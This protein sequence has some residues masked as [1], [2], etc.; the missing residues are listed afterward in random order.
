MASWSPAESLSGIDRVRTGH[1]CGV[2]VEITVIDSLLR[3]LCPAHLPAA[4]RP[5][6]TPFHNLAKVCDSTAWNWSP[7]AMP[8]HHCDA[9]KFNLGGSGITGPDAT[10]LFTGAIYL[11]CQWTRAGIIMRCHVQRRA[12]MAGISI[13]SPSC[14]PTECAA[15]DGVPTLSQF[16]SSSILSL[17]KSASWS[18][19]LLIQGTSI[20]MRTPLASPRPITIK[21]KPALLIE[22]Y[23]AP[24]SPTRSSA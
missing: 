4:C 7:L 8:C 21:K 5:G 18:K 19:V 12:Y 1:C 14:S 24:S 16:P 11:L 2:L 17:A 6:G 9:N 23:N 10:T 3:A 20:H 15:H 22:P 13:S